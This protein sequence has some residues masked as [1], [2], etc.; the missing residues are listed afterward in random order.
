[1]NKQTYDTIVVGATSFG[2][3]L[4]LR[5]TKKGKKVLI[6][7]ASHSTASDFSAP[8][9]GEKCDLKTQNKNSLSAFLV[10][11]DIAREDGLFLPAALPY[12]LASFI[13]EGKIECLY[14]CVP[15]KVTQTETGSLLL[16]VMSRRGGL[17][18]RTE[19]II[20]TTA[21]GSLPTPGGRGFANPDEYTT[22]LRAVCA[23][24]CGKN[25]APFQPIDIYDD[26]LFVLSLTVENDTPIGEA[27]LASDRALGDLR[28]RSFSV[29]TFAS[30]PTYTY[31]TPVSRQVYRSVHF[32][33]STS[34]SDPVAAFAAGEAYVEHLAEVTDAAPYPVTPV[35]HEIVEAD[36]AIVGTGTSGAVA[37]TCAA[38]EGARV[39]IADMNHT[40]GG[41]GTVTGVFDYYYG[42]HPEFLNRVNTAVKQLAD[43]DDR[44]L[45]TREVPLSLPLSYRRDLTPPPTLKSLAYDKLAQD[46]TVPP[47]YGYHAVRVATK[48][49]GDQKNVGYVDVTNGRRTVRLVAKQFID[50]ADGIL[51]R[52]AGAEF[53][54][55]RERDNVAA[56]TSLPAWTIKSG[57]LRQFLCHNGR[58][59]GFE[60]PWRFSEMLTDALARP[61]YL[62]AD[63]KPK[64]P[65]IYTAPYIGIREIPTVKVKNPYTLRNIIENKTTNKP[66]FHILAPLDITIDKPY[67]EN[68]LFMLYEMFGMHSHGI[69]AGLPIDVAFPEGFGNVLIAGKSIGVGHELISAARMKG[70]MEQE[71]EAVGR[72]AAL[73]IKQQIS[74]SDIDYETLRAHLSYPLTAPHE[75][76][77]LRIDE[78]GTW[79][80]VTLP[81]TVDELT[82]ILATDY[83]ALALYSIHKLSLCQ[84]GE[85]KKALKAIQ[86]HLSSLC[87]DE[88]ILGEQSAIALGFTGDSRA[89]PRLLCLLS[90]APTSRLHVDA[91]RH[92]H[93][94]FSKTAFKPY[95]LAILA[96]G[97][98]GI[99][100]PSKRDELSKTLRH[101][102]RN[103]ATI[104]ASTSPDAP[105]PYTAEEL[106]VCAE[107][108]M[109][110][111]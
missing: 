64:R 16:C 5:L 3:G 4:A 19:N 101:I 102:K 20:D 15:T 92:H 99:N 62:D 85:R 49:T 111:L 53:N 10:A 67:L 78:G 33:P 42:S 29:A 24:T 94:W 34:F 25:I 76:V 77:D 71:G 57:N 82:E 110:K 44:Y 56:P 109:E 58:F 35:Y 18:L 80:K 30:A 26:A 17:V 48:K 63:G 108:T 43:R 11:H 27:R 89:L 65:L 1:M 66:V 13:A 45:D 107:R 39:V 32:C 47:L 46:F 104:A 28:D 6:L 51:C 59:S 93:P 73:A 41:V 98:I 54:R 70:A 22:S 31:T 87:S 105:L 9:K 21:L 50:G 36:V 72:L 55:T 106:R 74:P 23:G 2:I 86:N 7:E 96:L 14:N 52:L 61:A 103:A 79:Q 88:G 95:T 97:Y 68:E 38:E 84:D 37:A 40:M 83:P 91:V 100:D 81:T 8:F 60:D 90:A 69:G 12:A 75:Y